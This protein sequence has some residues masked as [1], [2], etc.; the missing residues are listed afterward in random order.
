MSEIKYKKKGVMDA[1]TIVREVISVLT[2][3]E[4]ATAKTYLVSFVEKGKEASSRSVKLFEILLSLK[5]KDISSELI[6]RMVL[7]KVNRN[8][9]NHLTARLLSKVFEALSIDVNIEREGAYPETTKTNIAIRKNITHA[10]ILQKRGLLDV[11]AFLFE[12]IIKKGIAYEFYEE[13]LIAIRGLLRIRVMTEGEKSIKY[14]LKKYEKYD[15]F[16]N[17]VLHAEVN[18]GKVISQTE[19]HSHN[20]IKADWLRQILD[21][22]SE[23]FKKTRSIQIGYYYYYIETCF[24]QIQR[25]FSAARRSLLS[26]QRLLESGPAMNV[27]EMKGGVL[28]NLGEND[29]F[30]CEFDRGY[31][32]LEKAAV[33]LKSDIFNYEQCRESMFYAKFYEGEYK[34][35]ANVIFELQ[36]DTLSQDNFRKGKR[37]FLL[38]STYFMLGD[39]P[40]TLRHINLINPIKADK[41]GWNL[42]IKTLHIMTLIELKDFD[43]ATAK[44]D[45]LRKDFE[46]GKQN[47]RAKMICSIFH[48][49][50]YNGYNFKTTY[51]SEKGAIEMLESNAG[52]LAWQ[53]KSSEMIL[54]HQWIFA[55]AFRQEFVQKIPSF[56]ISIPKENSKKQV[57][58]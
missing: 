36:P 49:L 56:Q 8:S 51:Q 37:G 26:L 22:M 6:A 57:P 3:Q 30:L 27:A 19:F 16:K 31:D 4:K 42:G 58:G 18:Y 11:A 25:N 1:L 55:K 44:I 47:D 14:L 35:A 43:Q 52:A 23:D 17:A 45:S 9:F 29:L 33:F 34:I 54:F 7:G 15:S 53:I 12:K 39:F 32:H 10:Q 20:I 38:A 21:D 40:T 24:N 5:G 41:E 46:N 2:N 48:S 28:V 50:C 13:V